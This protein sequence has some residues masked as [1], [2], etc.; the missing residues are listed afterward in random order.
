MN[1]FYN[2]GIIHMCIVQPRGVNKNQPFT[3]IPTV[4]VLYDQTL[5]DLKGSYTQSARGEG[6]SNSRYFLAEELVYELRA[7]VSVVGP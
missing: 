3:S 1:A 4:Q 7:K 6:V 2:M 5:W